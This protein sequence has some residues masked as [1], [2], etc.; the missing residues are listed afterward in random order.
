M[1][2][3]SLAEEDGLIEGVGVV[4]FVTEVVEV[5][6]SDEVAVIGVDVLMLPVSFPTKIGTEFGPSPAAVIADTWIWYRTLSRSRLSMV[7]TWVSS[8][9]SDV[10]MNLLLS[11]SCPVA[12]T[13]TR[14]RYS[15]KIPLVGLGGNQE[16]MRELEPT[17]TA[18]KDLGALGAARNK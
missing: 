4:S 11:T 7:M 1:G 3:V 17:A 16:T 13:R 5:D 12:F 18:C 2:V 8:C 10:T 9:P 14:R 6:E 15:V